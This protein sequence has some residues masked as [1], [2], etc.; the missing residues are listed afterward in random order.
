MPVIMAAHISLPQV[1]GGDTPASL[2]KEIIG[3]LLRRDMGYDGV[4]ITDALNMGAISNHYTP[5]EACVLALSA[6]CDLLLVTDHFEES[7]QAVQEALR[8]GTF[9]MTRIDES[10]R[11]ILLLKLQM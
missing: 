9:T 1:T 3:G 4:V 5:G 2:S 10:V 11:R 6:G 7:Y 8:N